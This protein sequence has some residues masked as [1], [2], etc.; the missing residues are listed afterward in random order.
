VQNDRTLR[1]MSLDGGFGSVSV[2]FEDSS[3][4]LITLTLWAGRDNVLKPCQAPN[5]LKGT[6]QSSSSP[7]GTGFGGAPILR[8]RRIL[9]GSGIPDHRSADEKDASE[10]LAWLRRR[11]SG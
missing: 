6:A 10:S 9:V 7:S 4:V 8:E 3:K 11:T 2:H 5:H 1:S